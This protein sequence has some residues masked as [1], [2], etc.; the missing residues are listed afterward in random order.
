METR[1][2]KQTK[3]L[4]LI[5]E[6]MRFR[7]E[8]SERRALV[9]FERQKII[10]ECN[11]LKVER[12]EEPHPD[13]G[14]YKKVFKKDSILEWFNPKGGL[15]EEITEHWIDSEEVPGFIATYAERCV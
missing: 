7:V 15:T 11:K 8:N 10:D 13:G 4:V 14:T 5:L 9:S 2:I 12:Y 3:V 1:E 6:D